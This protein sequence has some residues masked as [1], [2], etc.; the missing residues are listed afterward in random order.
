MSLSYDDWSEAIRD[1]EL[2]GLECDDCGNITGAPKAACTECGSRS[3]SRVSLP[4]EGTV[5]SETTVAVAPEGFEGGYKVGIVE[6]G[7]TGARVLGRLDDEAEIG[8]EVGFVGVF[9]NRDEPAPVFG[10]R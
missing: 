9:E 3:V 10:L 8:D 2:V 6:L 1:G 4:D 5:Y 7:G